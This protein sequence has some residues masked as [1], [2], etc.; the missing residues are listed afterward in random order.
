MKKYDLAIVP[1]RSLRSALIAKGAKIPERIGFDI[2][3]APGQYT[4]L[5]QYRESI[6]ESMRN[7]ALLEPLQLRTTD[8]I[9]PQLFPSPQDLIAVESLLREFTLRDSRPLIA[10]AP[11]TVWN[12][13]RWFKE[14]FAQLGKELDVAGYD[15]VLI[16]GDDDVNLCNEILEIAGSSRLFT[17]AG[18]LSLLQSGAL[19]KQ[20]RVLVSNDSAPMHIAVAMKTPVVGIFGAT[21]PSFGFAPYGELDVIVETKDLACRPCTKHGGSKCPIKTFDCMTRITVDEVFQNVKRL[22]D[23]RNDPAGTVR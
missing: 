13:K 7:L 11:G 20:C 14:R 21:V 23:H 22:V 8:A 6:H 1:H 15:V 3:A 4:E 16:G 17:A 19:I 10:I 2:S 9:Y 5:V 12:T 18:R